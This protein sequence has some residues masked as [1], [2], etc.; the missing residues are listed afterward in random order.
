MASAAGIS[1][2]EIVMAETAFDSL[3]VVVCCQLGSSVNISVPFAALPFDFAALACPTLSSSYPT[4]PN[5][6]VQNYPF[7]VRIL[8]F[9]AFQLHLCQNP[10]GLPLPW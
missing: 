3:A 9:R 1:V 8:L 7:V 10:F 2:V 5:V 6:P 4:L